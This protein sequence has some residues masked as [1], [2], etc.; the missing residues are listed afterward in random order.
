MI[1]INLAPTTKKGRAPKA[2]A[3]RVPR[4]G[5][6]I[7]PI[8]TAIVYIIGIVIVVIIVVVLLL[9][10]NIQM[11]NYS[12]NINQLNV[13]LDELKVYKAAVDSLETR[14]REL[15]TL[16]APIRQLN[17]N[18]FFIAHILDEVS[19]RLP[20][21]TWLTMLTTDSTGMGIKGVAASNLLV[22]DFMN[23][24]EESPYIHNVDLTVL[25]KKVIEKQ[26]MMEF[27]L[28]ANVGVDSVA[29]RQR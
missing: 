21:F 1:K 26:E 27:T 14:E 10:Q 17:K 8:Q 3:A 6:K 15:A 4:P 2:R 18:R 7:P 24:L 12:G 22:A 28:T 13:K 16:I 23:R 20:D 9:S 19:T 25:E 11:R 29:W 5:I